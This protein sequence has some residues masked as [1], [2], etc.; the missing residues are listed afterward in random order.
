MQIVC[1]TLTPTSGEVTVNG[2]IGALLELGSG[3]NPEFTGIENIRITGLILGLSKKHIEE[4]MERII[5]FADIGDFINQPVKFYSSGM[6]VRLAFA[7]QAHIDPSIL[8]VDE[9]LAVGDELFQKKCFAPHRIKKRNKYFTCKSWCSQ[10]NQ[11]CDR[12]L[13][14]K[15]VILLS[16]VRQ[17]RS[18]ISTR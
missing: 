15:R 6:V 13:C 3:F 1:G 12:Q 9:A 2:R 16:K 4:K 11:H 14:C 7:V 8:V 5:A 18:P 10:I 17:V